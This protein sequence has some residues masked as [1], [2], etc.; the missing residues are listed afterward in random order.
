MRLKK[1]ISISLAGVMSVTA[2]A[3]CGQSAQS[4]DAAQETAQENAQETTQSADDKVEIEFWYSG[5]KTAVNVLGDMVEEFNASQDKYVIKGLVQ[6]D[7]TETYEKLQAGIAGNKAPD[8][9]LIDVDKARSLSD[10]NLIADISE[11]VNND[12]D[13]DRSDYL[14]V[15]YDQGIDENGKLFAFPAYGTT[16][17]MYYNIEAFEKAGIKAEDIKTWQDL[18]AA[19]EK[20]TAEDGSF[21]GW[22]PMWGMKNLIDAVHSNGGTMLNEDKTEVTINSEEWVEVWESFREWIHE[23]KIMKINSGGQGWEYWY[24]TIDDVLQDNAGG[25]TGSS[26]DQADLDFTKVAAMEQPGWGDNPSYPTAEV[27]QYV[28]LE[29]SSD[30]EKQGVYEFM[31]FFTTPENQAKWSM[32]TG[33]VSTRK[34]TE[35]VP[36]FKEYAENNPQILV[37]LQQAGHAS[38]LAEDPTNG[39]IYDALAIAADKVEIENVPA[40]EALDE[41]QKV[42]QEALD[43]LNG[44]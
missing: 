35:D 6:A 43:E 12:A 15:F 7:Y 16:Q 38:I 22:E 19:A 36:E 25:Y 4:S 37:P 1:W 5:G 13:F 44:K 18:E 17:V 29:G 23:D 26:G 8:I 31:K 10:K 32:E 9:A 41:A 28:M 24:K 30:E 2:L 27:L 21:V 20:M 42:A 11:Y 3:G 39:K 33:Y 34:S 40:Q 14:D